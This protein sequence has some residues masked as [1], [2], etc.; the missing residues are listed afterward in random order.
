MFCD[1]HESKCG[2]LLCCPKTPKVC[3]GDHGDHHRRRCLILPLIANLTSPRYSKA[4]HSKWMR[5][6][7]LRPGREGI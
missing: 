3:G 7:C 2:T 4:R 1:S 6:Y 5:L